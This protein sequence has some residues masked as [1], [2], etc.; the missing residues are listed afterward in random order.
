MELW[1]CV[2][3]ASPEDARRL[4]A[5]CCGAKRWVERMLSRRPFGDRGHALSVARD[6]WFALS[7]EDWREA[8]RQHPK[9]GDRDSLRARFPATHEQSAAEQS[10][11]SGAADAVLDAL[12]D[13]NRSYEKRFGYIFIVCATGKSADEMLAILR[14]RLNNDPR[15]EIKVAAEQQAQITA[16]RLTRAHANL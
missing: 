9:I 16:L 14:G 10:G 2:N 11:V 12:A 1:Q 6:V 4:L 7:E 3:D 8:F 5:T 15:I 13:A